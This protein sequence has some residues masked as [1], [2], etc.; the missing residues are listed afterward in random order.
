MNRYNYNNYHHG[1]NAF[2]FRPSSTNTGVGGQGAPMEGVVSS[3]ARPSVDN[4]R[5]SMF[6]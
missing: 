6:Q 2:A 5:G 3:N 4:G 1:T